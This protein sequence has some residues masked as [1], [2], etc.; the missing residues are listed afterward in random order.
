MTLLQNPQPSI[1]Q[2]IL[3]ILKILNPLSLTCDGETTRVKHQMENVDGQDDEM[4]WSVI[5]RRERVG[6]SHMLPDDNQLVGNPTKHESRSITPC[7]SNRID[8][9]AWW[10]MLSSRCMALESDVA[11]LGLNFLELRQMP[12][13]T[14]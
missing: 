5:R 8:E 3:K 10:D 4:C 6:L 9:N 13:I 1:S 14:Y 11:E 7:G 2:F 12:L